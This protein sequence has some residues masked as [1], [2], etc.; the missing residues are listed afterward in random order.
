MFRFHFH[1]L[2]CLICRLSIGAAVTVVAPSV[3]S[4]YAQPWMTGYY[5]AQNGVL[6]VHSI[7]WSQYTHIIHFAAST[8]G[9]GTVSMYYLTQA[10]INAL[11]ASRPAGKKVLLCIKD[12][13]NNY[14]AFPQS[15][16]ASNIAKFVSNIVGFVVGNG[17]DGVDID[18]EK[19]INVTQFEDLLTRLRTL[20]PTKVITIAANPGVKTVAAG[21]QAHLDQINVMCYDMDW[22]SSFSWYVDPLLQN[23][24]PNAL[25]CDWDVGQFTSAGVAP[26]KIGV[27]I[28]FYGRRWP[29]VT[30]ALQTS[31]F[32]NAITFAYRDLVTDDSRWQPQFQFFDNGY[33]AN[34]LS[35][36]V[37][38]RKEFD[39]YTGTQ[40][41]GDAVLWQKSKG[42][43]GFM[44]FTVEYE[45][46]A[47]EL[48]DAA[49]PLSTFL[50]HAVFDTS[51]SASLSPTSLTFGSQKIG[52]S[53]AVQVVT[54]RN[55][56][57]AALSITGILISGANSPD[58]SET[59]NCPGTLAVNASCQISAKFTP[60]AQGA[61]TA[62]IAVKD[63]AGNSPQTVP[64]SGKGT[65]TPQTAALS[66]GSVSLGSELRA[67]LK[68][69]R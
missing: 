65:G 20:M 9:D 45:Y 23:G 43:G 15:A 42:F 49:F 10:E 16:S 17:Y 46:L 61:R 22:G 25:T 7:P 34:Y 59:N 64:L 3:A 29:G 36:D 28:P 37:P 14:N 39:S 56:G 4:L 1:H 8:P 50:H 33:K 11:T 44:T 40:F 35:I 63:N 69:L 31:N 5:S 30:Q 12:N 52:T 18:W 55:A 51:P 68:P 48:G 38:G 27:G 66:P 53:S 24:N 2:L 60:K 62:T 19:N 21:S 32:N 58:F 41:L 57:T 6:P 67:P 54:L 13:D 47:S 26:G